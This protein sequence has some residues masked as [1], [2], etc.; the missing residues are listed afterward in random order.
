MTNVLVL[1][2]CLL[3]YVDSTSSLRASAVREL[4]GLYSENKQY[5]S[6]L[7]A[8]GGLSPN[9]SEACLKAI[10]GLNSSN[11]EFGKCE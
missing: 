8:S 3:F 4:T 10:L 1:I 5:V 6:S 7:T 11:P 2:I 9:V